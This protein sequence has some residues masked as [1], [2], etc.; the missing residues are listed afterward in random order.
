MTRD[1]PVD[2][3]RGAHGTKPRGA[4]GRSTILLEKLVKRC[5]SALAL[6][7]PLL[8]LAGELSISCVGEESPNCPVVVDVTLRQERLTAEFQVGAAAG[9][10][11]ATILNFCG[12]EGSA[13]NIYYGEWVANQKCVV[14]GKFRVL[15]GELTKQQLADGAMR[16]EIHTVMAFCDNSL[17]SARCSL[18]KR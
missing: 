13:A 2:W 18:V 4:V 17:G 8:A 11:T 5:I 10:S 7:L 3:W 15:N 1:N 9:G 14:G 6:C 12:Y 16:F